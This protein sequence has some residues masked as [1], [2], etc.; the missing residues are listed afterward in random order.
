MKN[1]R[2]KAFLGLFSILTLSLLNACKVKTANP[3]APT[4]VAA[5]Q[6]N[7]PLSTLNLPISLEV[8]DLQD[9]INNQFK[10]ILYNDNSF[11][12]NNDD[13]LILKVTKIADFK[14]SA[15][16]DKIMIVAPLS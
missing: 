4:K 15:K 14:L 6:V 7:R 1:L 16:G 10:G 13:N 11:E 3:P 12:N 2:F 9:A 5:V 8:E